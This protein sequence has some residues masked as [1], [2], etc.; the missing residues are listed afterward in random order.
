M[1]DQLELT[2]SG[3][4]FAGASVDLPFRLLLELTVEDPDSI[5][6]LCQHQEGDERERQPET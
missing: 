4:A 2:P 6:E 5:A 1:A 3:A